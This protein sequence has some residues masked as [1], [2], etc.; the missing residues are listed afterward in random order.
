MNAMMRRRVKERFH[1]PEGADQLRVNPELVK[2][3]DGL[4]GHHHD[5]WETNQRQPQPEN[6][7][8]RNAAGPRLAE[9]GAEVITL[10]RMMDYMRSP[11]KTA[12][13][14]TAM[15]D[16][17]GEIFGEEQEHPGP[18][19]VSDMEDGEAMDE[20]IAG[21]QQDLG[22]ETDD[23]VADAHGKAGGRVFPFK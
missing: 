16:V 10:R 18:P 4:H 20:A 17:V 15:E 19:L 13:M 5:G 9:S 21:E 12:F 1:R 22:E 8:E 23:H 3:A 11:E 14:A 7:A 2:Q 6:E